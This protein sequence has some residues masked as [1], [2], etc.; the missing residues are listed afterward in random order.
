VVG[1]YVKSP[2][3]KVAGNIPAKTG[4][5]QEDQDG[6]LQYVGEQGN[7]R[8]S[9]LGFIL[10]DMPRHH[11]HAGTMAADTSCSGLSQR[12]RLKWVHDKVLDDTAKP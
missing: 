12:L 8:G 3:M 10:S 7:F 2:L 5:I 6:N 4:G 11:G 1:Y 9:A